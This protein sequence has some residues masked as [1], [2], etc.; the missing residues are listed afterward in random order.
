MSARL[1]RLGR[2]GT[3]VA[4]V[5]LT[6]VPLP[7]GSASAG[8]QAAPPRSTVVAAALPTSFNLPVPANNQDGRLEVFSIGSDSGLWHKWQVVPN[9]GWSGWASLGGSLDQNHAPAVGMN[10]DGRLEVFAVSAGKLWHSWQLVP[11]GGWSG[12][13]S[14]GGPGPGGYVYSDPAVARDAAGRLAVFV[15]GSGYEVYHTTQLAPGGAWSSWFALYRT[16]DWYPVGSP[17]VGVNG[18]GRLEVFVSDQ[19]ARL[20][21]AWQLYPGSSSW[22]GWGHNLGGNL[23]SL[24]IVGKNSDGRLEIF[25]VHFGTQAMWQIW[26]WPPPTG[27]WS[28]WRSMGGA[29]AGNPAVGRNWDGRLELF[30]IRASDQSLWHNWQMSAGGAWY[31]F[32]P[33]GGGPW[34]R[35]PTVGSNQDRRLEVFTAGGGLIYHRYQVTPGGNWGPWIPL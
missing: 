35:S 9:G 19:Y 28:A 3:F 21:H 29:W 20:R 12:W 11:N 6:L 31:G 5:G 22:S 7:T 14:L 13:A 16:S 26:Q 34:T 10:A 27:G 17:T 2:W 32:V 18:D 15:V 25:A 24:P 4:L 30:A 1:R 8:L 23:G 33:L